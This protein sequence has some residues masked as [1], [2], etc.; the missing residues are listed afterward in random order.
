[1]KMTRNQTEVNSKPVGYLSTTLQKLYG[2]EYYEKHFAGICEP[3]ERFAFDCS[4]KHISETDLEQI[5]PAFYV[6]YSDLDVFAKIWLIN[7]T[8]STIVP[9]EDVPC[10]IMNDS[11]RFMLMCMDDVDYIFWDAEDL[12]VNLIDGIPDSIHGI[13]RLIAKKII[14]NRVSNE[15]SAKLNALLKKFRSDMSTF[16][17]LTP[18]ASYTVE[19][20]ATKPENWSGWKYI[21]EARDTGWFKNMMEIPTKA[22]MKVEST[23]PALEPAA[24]EPSYTDEE[25]T[26]GMEQAF[27]ELMEQLDPNFVMPPHKKDDDEI[28]VETIDMKMIENAADAMG[29]YISTNGGIAKLFEDEFLADATEDSAAFSIGTVIKGVLTGGKIAVPKLIGILGPVID[30]V[31]GTIKKNVLKQP[32]AMPRSIG[33]IIPKHTQVAIDGSV[34]KIEGLANLLRGIIAELCIIRDAEDTKTQIDAIDRMGKLLKENL[35]MFNNTKFMELMDR[36]MGKMFDIAD[37]AE[38]GI[39]SDVATEVVQKDEGAAAMLPPTVLPAVA[40]AQMRD[41]GTP[42]WMKAIG[43]ITS[44]MRQERG[45]MKPGFIDMANKAAVN[46]NVPATQQQLNALTPNFKVDPALEKDYPWINQICGI[47]VQNGLAV[48]A[49]PFYNMKEDG[50]Y[51][52]SAIRVESFVDGVPSKEKSFTI[53]LG[54][55]LDRRVKMVF[56][57]GVNGFGFLEACEDAYFVFDKNNERGIDTK[58]FNAIFKFGISSI[59]EEEKRGMRMYNSNTTKV[60]RT[61]VWITVPTWAV[62]G[63]DRKALKDSIFKMEKTI[64]AMAKK[65]NLNFGRFAL[66]GFDAETMSYTLDNANVW[67]KGQP[68]NA[69]HFVYNVTIARNEDGTYKKD[70][71]GH[72]TVNCTI[73]YA[74]NV[75][76]PE[77]PQFPDDASIICGSP[78]QNTELFTTGIDPDESGDAE[79]ETP[80]EEK[81]AEKPAEEVKPKTNRRTTKKSTK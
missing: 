8:Q 31:T 43:D 65:N 42:Y 75:F 46:M 76:G 6:I 44:A 80:V 17:R 29:E 27:V 73:S 57:Y 68:C 24:E 81:D 21:K 40:D 25:I 33:E 48:S 16:A 66:Y 28:V 10:L 49:T 50:S 59:K 47:A 60:N 9:Y 13:N 38:A 64:R 23:K 77:G 39:S 2:K 62:K 26:A 4:E 70:A 56:N 1:M 58:I 53:D 51:E 52:I 61:I 41:D 37:Q 20:L 54:N 12:D 63:E 78:E 5:Y 30:I 71:E 36:F 67:F 22:E 72:A 74:D 32:D 7:Q 18:Y 11:D 35:S 34:D 55:F 15:E 45:K 79:S 3:F 69:P 14:K 19:E